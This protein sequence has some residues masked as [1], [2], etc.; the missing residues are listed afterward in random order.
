MVGE[1]AGESVGEGAPAVGIEERAREWRARDGGVALFARQVAR[2]GPEHE[3][4]YV[5]RTEWVD[6]RFEFVVEV[7][8]AEALP[9]EESSSP[10]LGNALILDDASR[11]VDA[12]QAVPWTPTHFLPKDDG[13]TQKDCPRVTPCHDRECRWLQHDRRVSSRVMRSGVILA[14]GRSTRFGDADKAVEPLAGKPMVRRVAERVGAVT[15]GVVVNCRPDQEDAI[16]DALTDADLDSRLA[17]DPEPDLGPVGGIRTGLGE[18]NG[19]YA[20]VVACDMPFVDPSF[21]SYLFDR[22]DGADGAVPRPDEYFEVTQAVYRVDA[23]HRA[24]DRALDEPNP[25]I[26]APLEH[27]DIR[28]IDGPE[29]ATHAEPGTFQNV[30]TRKEFDAAA[31]LLGSDIDD[32][33]RRDEAGEDDAIDAS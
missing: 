14:G 23:M 8:G 11:Q 25:K 18:A 7:A 1:A 6:A 24:C 16:V 30:N 19:E 5:V 27:L 12:K 4:E 31:A 10:V 15:D 21:L 28:V 29:V 17:L 33:V 9:A 13:R 26:L 20:T 32:G 2:Q 3:R 22:A